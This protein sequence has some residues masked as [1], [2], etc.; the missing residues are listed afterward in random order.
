MQIKMEFDSLGNLSSTL[1][2]YSWMSNL[3]E[4]HFLNFLEKTGSFG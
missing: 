1:L 2:G 3:I 4:A